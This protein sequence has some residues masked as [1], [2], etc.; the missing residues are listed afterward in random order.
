MKA[1]LKLNNLTYTPL[2]ATK[3]KTLIDP[4]VFFI[5]SGKITGPVLQSTF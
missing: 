5:E 4:S 2:V 1:T 3:N